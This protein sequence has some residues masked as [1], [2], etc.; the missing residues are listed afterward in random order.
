[1]F[2]YFSS[3]LMLTEGL[4]GFYHVGTIMEHGWKANLSP[5]LKDHKK[6]IDQNRWISVLF[7]PCGH[8]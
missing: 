8:L 6:V 3:N 4:E 2:F 5:T 7:S 1:M